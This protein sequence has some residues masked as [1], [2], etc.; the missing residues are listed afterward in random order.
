M[1]DLQ[2]SRYSKPNGNMKKDELFNKL[3]EVVEVNN[4]YVDEIQK[5]RKIAN[6]DLFMTTRDISNKAD[7]LLDQLVNAADQAASI[8]R[9]MGDCRQQIFELIHRKQS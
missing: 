9:E 6:P 3:S 5:L 7:S 2:L 1:N 8:A 4:A